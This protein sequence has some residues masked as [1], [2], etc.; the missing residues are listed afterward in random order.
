MKRYPSRFPIG[1]WNYQKTNNVTPEDVKD[2]HDLGM[3]FAHSPA[4]N[5][6]QHE[7]QQMLDILDACEKYDI[8]LIMDDD[9]V[10]WQDAASDPEGYKAR[11]QEALD[12]FGSHE[13]AM[14]RYYDHMMAAHALKAIFNTRS[15]FSQ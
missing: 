1:F 4:Y 7:K 15:E 5:P 6:E 10:F 13:L 14:E 9:R 3:T 11:F 12:D 8:R 2:W